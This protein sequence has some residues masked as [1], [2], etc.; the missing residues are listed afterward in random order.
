MLSS[1][2]R[3][4]LPNGRSAAMNNHNGSGGGGD[5]GGSA[6]GG[7][8]LGGVANYCP[9]STFTHYLANQLRAAK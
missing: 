6:S 7:A 1:V 2:Q 8:G 9:K 4:L 3:F 5:S